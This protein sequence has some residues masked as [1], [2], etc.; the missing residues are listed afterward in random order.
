MPAEDVVPSILDKLN[1]ALAVKA[2]F[3]LFLIFYTI[4]ALILYRE[5]QIMGKSLPTPAVP[6]LKF[7]AIVHI[8]LALA[9]LFVVLG[10]F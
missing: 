5:I 10:V 9:L 3:I 2:F 8:G 4:F 7:V 6:F 1:V